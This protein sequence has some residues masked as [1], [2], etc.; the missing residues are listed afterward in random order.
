MSKRCCCFNQLNTEPYINN[1]FYSNFGL[2]HFMCHFLLE[3]HNAPPYFRAWGFHTFLSILSRGLNS[4]STR[5]TCRIHSCLLLSLGESRSFVWMTLQH[6]KVPLGKTTPQPAAAASPDR[7]NKEQGRGPCP[8][9][10]MSYRMKSILH[11]L[12][13]QTLQSGYRHPTESSADALAYFALRSEEEWKHSYWMSSWGLSSGYRTGSLSNL[14]LSHNGLWFDQLSIT[15]ISKLNSY[16]RQPYFK[17]DFS[18]PSLSLLISRTDKM[19]TDDQCSSAKVQHRDSS[20]QES[21]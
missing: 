11:L 19:N 13:G 21:N 9:G 15:A 8:A 18:F 4:R 3:V 16:W 10:S 5:Q 12:S 1:H 6:L 14:F 20:T 17:L 7:T 2:K